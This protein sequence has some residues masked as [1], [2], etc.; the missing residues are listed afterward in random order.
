MTIDKGKAHL[1]KGKGLDDIQ[2]DET[3]VL[4]NEEPYLTV[5]KKGNSCILCNDYTV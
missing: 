1:Y 4:E 3:D 2:I 5:P